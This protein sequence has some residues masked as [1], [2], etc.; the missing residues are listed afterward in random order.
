MRYPGGNVGVVASFHRLAAQ[1]HLVE[2]LH[3]GW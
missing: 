3:I 2:V 1:L